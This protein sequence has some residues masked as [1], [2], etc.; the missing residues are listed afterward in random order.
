MTSVLDAYK[1]FDTRQPGWVKVKLEP[2]ATNSRLIAAGGCQ[3]PVQSLVSG[4]AL[5]PMPDVPNAKL[6][7]LP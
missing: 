1:A 6:K 4:I 2:S 7:L 5:K 3:E